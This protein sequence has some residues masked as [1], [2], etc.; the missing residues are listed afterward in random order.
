[1]SAWRV[2]SMDMRGVSLTAAVLLVAACAEP[3]PNGSF[4][5]EGPGTARG[6]GILKSS[7]DSATKGWPGTEI[8]IV[9]AAGL[10]NADQRATIQRVI[11]SVVARDTAALWLRVTTLA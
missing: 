11:D 7:R 5:D 4:T 6:Y 9:V 3:K 1:M 2:W 8:H 10:S